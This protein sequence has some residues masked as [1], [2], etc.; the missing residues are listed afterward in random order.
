[1]DS[2]ALIKDA[3]AMALVLGFLAVVSGLV[4]AMLLRWCH[5]Q[6]PDEAAGRRQAMQMKDAA[7]DLGGGVSA[8]VEEILQLER[9]LVFWCGPA[10]DRTSARI[11]LLPPR[12]L[13][14]RASHLQIGIE[15]V[16]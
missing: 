3:L 2:F 1:M 7:T 8:L 5:G 13:G 15:R 16:A 10:G 4:S 9:G 11:V 12:L 6:K 14:S